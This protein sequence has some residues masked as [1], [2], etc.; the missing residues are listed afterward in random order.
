MDY[1]HQ[2]FEGV[3]L[4]NPSWKRIQLNFKNLFNSPIGTEAGLKR[5]KLIQESNYAKLLAS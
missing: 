4:N 5:K 3:N 1:P 2:V